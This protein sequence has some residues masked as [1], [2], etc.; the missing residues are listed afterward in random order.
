MVAKAAGVL[1]IGHGAENITHWIREDAN[2]A[3]TGKQGV[4][5]FEPNLP[6][7]H[8]LEL[9]LRRCCQSLGTFA[10]SKKSMVVNMT[11]K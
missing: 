9:I 3:Q 8:V 1:G 7:C 2:N 4:Q 5:R 10:K 6:V 11:R